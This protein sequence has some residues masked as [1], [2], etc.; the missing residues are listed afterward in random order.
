M[1]Y[2][3]LQRV[4]KILL[5]FNLDFNKILIGFESSRGQDFL[6]THTTSLSIP[7]MQIILGIAKKY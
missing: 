4:S 2:L 7:G 5:G 1:N 3:E 6:G